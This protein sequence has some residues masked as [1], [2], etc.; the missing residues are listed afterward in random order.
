ARNGDSRGARDTYANKRFTIA[1]G[2]WPVCGM[3]S[4]LAAWGAMWRA[5]DPVI[6]FALVTSLILV[7]ASLLMM[8]QTFAYAQLRARTAA[9]REDFDARWRPRLV[10][11]SLDDEPEPLP[12]PENELERTWLLLLWNRLQRHLRGS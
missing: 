4:D 1:R 11:A 7:S 9:R 8:A 2:C 10:A 5:G 12:A 3:P 6:K